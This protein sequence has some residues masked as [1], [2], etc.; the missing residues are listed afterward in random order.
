MNTNTKFNKD[1]DNLKNSDS[2][3]VSHE[4]SRV[5]SNICY[6]QNNKKSFRKNHPQRDQRHNN[7]HNTT[8]SSYGRTEMA[9]P[10]PREYDRHNETLI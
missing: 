6:T 8:F 7:H 5:M 3:E 9:S 4:N 2:Y 1:N 10:N